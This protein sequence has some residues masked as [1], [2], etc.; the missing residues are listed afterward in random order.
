[1]LW[2]L[3]SWPLALWALFPLLWRLWCLA[4][5]APVSLKQALLGAVSRLLFGVPAWV[6]WTVVLGIVDVIAGPSVST[7]LDVLWPLASMA[8]ALWIAS[9]LLRQWVRQWDRR[10]G[11]A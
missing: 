3:L 6:A 4:T 8:L 10:Q 7:V 9:P 11:R 1:M 5:A 2:V